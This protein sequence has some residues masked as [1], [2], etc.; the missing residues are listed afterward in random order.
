MFVV[1]AQNTFSCALSACIYFSKLNI[2]VVRVR[3]LGA[4]YLREYAHIF[5]ENCP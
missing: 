2:Y 5:D 1:R 4:L 3:R